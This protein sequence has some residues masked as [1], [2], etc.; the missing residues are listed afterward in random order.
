MAK[1]RIPDITLDMMREQLV[2]N[3]VVVTGCLSKYRMPD[4][5]FNLGPI[6]GECTFFGY[7]KYFPSWGLCITV[8]GM[9][10]SNVTVEQITVL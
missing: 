1:G 7:N 10:L 2:G 9:P 4:G 8:D 6:K 3:R 5:S